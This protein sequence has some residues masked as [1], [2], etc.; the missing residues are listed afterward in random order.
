MKKKSRLRKRAGENKKGVYIQSLIK[1]NIRITIK[2]LPEN[3]EKSK[4]GWKFW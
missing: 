2:L 4:S 1:E 3:T